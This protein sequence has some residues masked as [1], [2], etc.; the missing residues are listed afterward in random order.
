MSKNIQTHNADYKLTQKFLDY[1]NVADASYAL[2]HYINDTIQENKKTGEKE[3]GDKQKLGSIYFNQDTNTEQISTYARAIEARFEQDTKGKEYKN[4]IQ[5]VSKEIDSTQY[6]DSN[7]CHIFNAEINKCQKLY[8]KEL[9]DRTINFTNRF[10]LLFH[11]P[12]TDS[13]FSATLFKD[14]KAE[15]ADSEYILAFRGTE[16]S[17]DIFEADVSL[18]GGVIPKKQYLDMLDFYG[19]C[20]EKSY[21]TESTP[22]IV[23]GHSLGGCLTQLFALSFATPTHSNIVKEIYTFNSSGAKKLDFNAVLID[24]N[25]NYADNLQ[26]VLTLKRMQFYKDKIDELL[27]EIYQKSKNGYDM[28]NANFHHLLISAK[29][30]RDMNSYSQLEITLYAIHLNEFYANKIANFFTNKMLQQPLACKDSIHH[31]EADDDSNPDNNKKIDNL[32][33]DLGKDIDGKH[34]LLNILGEHFT[35]IRYFRV[36]KWFDSHYLSPLIMTLQ[37]AIMLINGKV[38]NG[39]NNLLEYNQY[40]EQ[41]SQY[42]YQFYSTHIAQE[43]IILE[44]K[45]SND[46]DISQEELETM[47]MEMDYPT[48]FLYAISYI[49]DKESY[50]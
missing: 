40:K 22:L 39:I 47:I 10:K 29:A 23:V 41:I 11:Q 26:K 42:E 46:I 17:K 34:Y 15:F 4:K 19:E 50:A 28:P 1:A 14:T 49:T 12:N 27:R 36:D 38:N 20:I 9:S 33:Q 25:D 48:D 43:N 24:M 6:K 21:I 35:G 18:I 30:Q 37:E 7:G 13:G 31:I 45:L 2:L 44:A 32:I 16:D 5:N 3:K 8:P